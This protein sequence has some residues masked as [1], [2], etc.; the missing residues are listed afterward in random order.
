MEAEIDTTLSSSSK[1]STPKIHSSPINLFVTTKLEQN[2]TGL[3][4]SER[5]RNL[6]W[7][8]PTITSEEVQVAVEIFIFVGST[9]S[10]SRLTT[11]SCSKLLDAP[12]STRRVTM[13]SVGG[14]WRLMKNRFLP[15]LTL[16]NF[17]FFV[18]SSLCFLMY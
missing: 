4:Y 10:E 7:L 9:G 8:V 16:N 11:L 5:S 12:V 13:S 2:S 17:S 14:N 1:N 3:K 18:V 6:R 15:T